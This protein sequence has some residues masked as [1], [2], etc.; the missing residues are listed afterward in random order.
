MIFDIL[1]SKVN[2]NCSSTS[3]IRTNDEADDEKKKINNYYLNHNI[4]LDKLN[5]SALSNFKFTNKMKNIFPK[6]SQNTQIILDS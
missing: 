4:V 3:V 6:T 5:K 2:S 1:S